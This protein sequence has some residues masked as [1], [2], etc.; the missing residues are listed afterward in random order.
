MEL[1]VLRLAFGLALLALCLQLSAFGQ[2]STISGVI[3]IYTPVLSQGPC[4]NVIT[5]ASSA[6][7]NVGDTVLI[8]QMQGATIDQTNTASFGN[9]SSYN[10]AGLFEKAEILSISGGTV[11]F[12]QDLI[13][14][15]NFTGKVQMISVPV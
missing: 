2:T 3:N 7:F 12:T 8:I 5:V 14:T 6:G 4:A 13:Y 9:I 15:Y 1:R 11:Y 10:S